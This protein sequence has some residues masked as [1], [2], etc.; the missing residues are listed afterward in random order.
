M[1]N[2]ATIPI[3]FCSGKQERLKT[4]V[5][6]QHKDSNIRI[7]IETDENG[8]FLKTVKSFQPLIILAKKIIY[9]FTDLL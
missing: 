6:F 7:C 9:H 1:Q 4:F 5:K 2:L 3:D 8:E